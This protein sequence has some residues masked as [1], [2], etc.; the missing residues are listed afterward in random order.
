MTFHHNNYLII[1]ENKLFLWFNTIII[2]IIIIATMKILL[3][4]T[5]IIIFNQSIAQ[6]DCPLNTPEFPFQTDSWPYYSW[7]ANLYTPS[8]IGSAQTMTFISFRLDNDA[9]NGCNTYTY[10]NCKIWVRNSGVVDYAGSLGYPGTAGFTEVYSGNF[11]FTGPGV[12]TYNFN[13]APSFN[14]DGTST[15]EVLFESRGGS[16]NTWDE[17]W[18]DRTNARTDGVYPGRVGWGN[19]WV[20]ATTSPSQTSNRLF[21]LQINNTTC[22]AYPLPVTLSSSTLDC[23]NEF[24]TI[25]WVTD[26]E[27]NNDYFTIE[28]SEDGFTWNKEKTIKGQGSSQSRKFYSEK[29]VKRKR[30]ETNY[31]RLSQTDF[32]GTRENLVTHS[33]DCNNDDE[34][35]VFP[36]PFSKTLTVVNGERED[37][38]LF[39]VLGN[40]KEVKLIHQEDLIYLDT[41]ELTTG[42]YILKV[43]EESIKVVKK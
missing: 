16:D 33:S 8:Q 12:Y 22:G 43:G 25:N 30:F 3:L 26:S 10:T 35:K 15:F 5:T 23:D 34:I 37:I 38:M 6:I 2:I 18:F 31:Y 11:T 13:V 9:C 32:N 19:S 36:N 21:N 24:V 40:R 41:E 7:S 14:Y 29:I 17:P 27:D 4:F 39:D 1:R 28:S 42:I 20:D